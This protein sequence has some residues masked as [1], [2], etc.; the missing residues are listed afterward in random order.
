MSSGIKVATTDVQ[1]IA[2][3]FFLGRSS[4]I[5]APKTGIKVTRL[6]K[7]ILQTP[8]YLSRRLMQLLKL[9]PARSYSI[10]SI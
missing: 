3:I 7:P 1:R 6:S 9:S 10:H 8:D 5:I 4:T 2:A